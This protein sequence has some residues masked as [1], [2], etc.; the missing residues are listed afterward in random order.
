[1]ENVIEEVAC[2]KY[3]SR[4]SN[5]STL[6]VEYLNQWKWE[7][8]RKEA[9]SWCFP[10]ALLMCIMLNTAVYLI[11]RLPVEQWGILAVLLNR[12][13]SDVNNQWTSCLGCSGFCRKPGLTGRGLYELKPEC[14]RNF[15]LYFYHFSRAE[16]SKVTHNCLGFGLSSCGLLFSK[17]WWSLR[18][19]I[20]SC[21]KVSF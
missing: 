7:N 21:F 18:W 13:C 5:I 14:A 4:N 20:I 12:L 16:Q 17:A 11:S 19:S 3:V 15:N 1:M 2:F 8:R 6:K 10:M 9:V